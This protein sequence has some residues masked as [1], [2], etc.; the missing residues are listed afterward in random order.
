MM[1]RYEQAPGGATEDKMHMPTLRWPIKILSSLGLSA[2]C[3]AAYAQGTASAGAAPDGAAAANGAAAEVAPPAPPSAEV[4]SYDL[5][6]MLGNQ[7]VNNGFGKG[8]SRKEL[9][10]GID[11]ALAG[12][13]PSAEQR[14]AVQR[15]SRANREAL[16]ASNAKLAKEFLARNANAA[17]ITTM[18]SGLQYRVLAAGAAKAEPPAPTD[19]VTLRYRV[20]LADGTVLDRSEDHPQKQPMFRVNRVIPAWREALLAMRPGAK[21]KLFVPPE[22]G[23]GANSP[24]PI[25]PGALLI[26]DLDLL[27]VE[28]A[29]QMAPLGPATAAPPSAARPKSP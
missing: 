5:G 13:I 22:L 19:Q 1:G 11:D 27:Q 23:Y 4:G 26:F 15:F 20:S 28:R 3:F 16:A 29:P 18:P 7:L 9:M 24:P 6:L 10:R 2:A 14:E 25:P 17:G 21:W 8:A 12:K